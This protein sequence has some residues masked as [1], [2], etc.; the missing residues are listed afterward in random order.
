MQ[1]T[2]NFLGN[3]LA[4][5]NW[6]LDFNHSP[7]FDTLMK[8]N[9]VPT[10]FQSHQL[11]TS[12][13][14]LDPSIR[15]IQ[16]EI[17]LLRNTATSLESRML[18][19]MAIRRDYK[20]ALSP[21][22]RLPVEVLGEI[23]CCTRERLR[24]QLYYVCGFDVFNISDGPWYLGHVCRAWRVAVETFCPDLWS[25]MTIEFP[26]R[27]D[28]NDIRPTFPFFGKNMLAILERALE[29]SRKCDLNF[30]FRYPGY[31]NDTWATYSDAEETLIKQC[32]D[33][34]LTHSTRWR[35]V[36]LFITPFLLAR[37]P[38]IR[39]R[40]NNLQHMYLMCEETAE[41]GNID[42]FE[43]APK[44]KTLHL[45]DM[46]PEAIIMF[47]QR[48]LITFLDAR[49]LSDTDRTPEQLDLIASC[50]NLLSFSYHHH[51]EIPKSFGAQFPITR[52]TSI[53]S[54][55]AS[56]AKFISSL[57]LPALNRMTVRS[58]LDITGNPDFAEIACP[59]DA[60]SGLHV[61]ITRSGCSLTVLHLIDVPTMD[62]Q[63]LSI[64]RLTPQLLA[65]TIELRV[66]TLTSSSLNSAKLQD[67]FRHMAENQGEGTDKKYILIPSLKKMAIIIRELNFMTIEFLDDGFVDMV[68]S[69]GASGRSSVF[70]GLSVIVSGRE[71]HVP[72][73]YTPARET[74]E[75]LV[76][77][78]LRL[79]LIV[80]DGMN[81]V[82][83]V[84]EAHHSDSE[85]DFSV[86]F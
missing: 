67:I 63:L 53:R 73:V 80:N 2:R 32:F 35:S 14:G 82:G 70:E 65:L 75:A 26:D 22:R 28:K 37:L 29:R 60:L 43:I 39:G 17:V 20:G 4:R 38:R 72:F 68:I 51:S 59:E 46:H 77:D 34:L 42:A 62:D 74:L 78:G 36:E 52:N 50:S 41:P 57:D 58:G 84:D 83:D 81:W 24:Y 19:L 16:A 69:R 11:N 30:S 23:L 47:P 86:G 64:L 55:S 76:E 79:Q 61:L 21:I 15:D 13:Q 45:T 71:C 31:Y 44:L 27:L 10:N 8:T 9:T 5:Y 56:L 54:L 48:N 85:S 7:E 33:L 40:V 6:I 66:F 49:P 12:I 3:L 1:S 25:E 18:R